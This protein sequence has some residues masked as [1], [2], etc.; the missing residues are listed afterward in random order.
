MTIKK[1]EF[2]N[3]HRAS[4]FFDLYDELPGQV[5]ISV[6]EPNQFSGWHMHKLQYDKFT[7]VCGRVKVVVI[8]QDGTINEH[9]L[10]ASVPE[11]LH[12]LPTEI[13][14]YKNF[15]E[16]SVLSYYLSKK[17]NEA[18]EYRF[19]EEEIYKRFKYKI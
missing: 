1:L 14:S 2:Y 7:V 9:I 5:T 18:D 16:K 11:T 10:D 8:K 17:H 3:D 12:I 6:I 13:H 19:S 4:R 15:S